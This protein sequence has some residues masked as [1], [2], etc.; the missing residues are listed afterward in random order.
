MMHIIGQIIFG[1]II[2]AIAQLL[3]VGNDPGSWSVKG[4]AITCVIGVI[5]SLLGTLIGRALW[6]GEKYSAGWV[7]SILGAI[8]LLLLYRMFP[9]FG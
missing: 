9:V 3:V 4:F 2:G 1:L 6:G 5:G 7:M 8:I